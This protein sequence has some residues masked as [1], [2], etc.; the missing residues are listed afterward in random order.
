MSLID[1]IYTLIFIVSNLGHRYIKHD[2]TIAQ[3]KILNHS[4]TQTFMY[5]S[6]VYFSTRNLPLSIVIVV[7]TYLLFKVFLNE[8]NRYNIFSKSWL[9]QN[10]IIDEYISDKDVYINNIYRNHY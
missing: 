5:F 3:D 8:N 9:Y 6:I 10:K 2:I 7:I 1:P 4:V